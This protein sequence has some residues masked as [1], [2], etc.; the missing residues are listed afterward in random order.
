MMMMMIMIIIIIIIIIISF[1]ILLYYYL[2]GP[3]WVG[4]LACR[5]GGNVFGRMAFLT[6]STGLYQ[7]SFISIFKI[8]FGAPCLFIL[9]YPCGNFIWYLAGNTLPNPEVSK[10]FS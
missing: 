4:P 9:Q 10:S 2:T 8:I 6:K 7:S 5:G 3:V 1:F